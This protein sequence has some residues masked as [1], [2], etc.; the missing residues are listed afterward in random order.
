MTRVCVNGQVQL[1]KTIFSRYPSIPS[2]STHSL[3]TIHSYNFFIHSCTDLVDRIAYIR[4]LLLQLYGEMFSIYILGLHSMEVSYYLEFICGSVLSYVCD[5]KNEIHFL[6][7][8]AQKLILEHQSKPQSNLQPL[9]QH[10]E[11]HKRFNLKQ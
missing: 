8:L 10:Q 9:L 6:A 3:S 5:Q 2:P 4:H 1:A 11:V 7:F